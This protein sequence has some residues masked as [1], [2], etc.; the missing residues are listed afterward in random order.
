MKQ[1]RV[2]TKGDVKIYNYTE[3][4]ISDDHINLLNKGLS[5]VLTRNTCLDDVLIEM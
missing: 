4:D 2:V 3:N 5:F 1:I